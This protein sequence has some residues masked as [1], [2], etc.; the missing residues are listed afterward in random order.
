MIKELFLINFK[1]EKTSLILG[2]WILSFLLHNLLSSLLGYEEKFFFII[3]VLVIPIY[4]V[5][6][7]TYSIIKY[8]KSKE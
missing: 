2:V 6:A 1:R 7:L 3:A 4:F 8:L 5:I